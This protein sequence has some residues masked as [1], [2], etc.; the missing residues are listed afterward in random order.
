MDAGFDFRRGEMR[1][2]APKD[3]SR[4]SEIIDVLETHPGVREA[5][6]IRDCA[7]GYR[8]FVVPND[9]YMDNVLGRELAGATV[10]D[11]WRKACELS[12]LTKEVASVPVGFNTI[13]WNSTYTRQ[14]I[15]AD[16][17]REWVDATVA[18]ILKLEPRVVYE[19]GCGTG[20]PLLRI[21]P[22]CE[23][24]V[25]VD[26]S[27]VVL[28]RLREQL[29]TIPAARDRVELQERRADDFD[30]LEE[31]S[32]DTV[33]LNSIVQYFP[34]ATYLTSVLEKA[35]HVVKPGGHVFV[36]D[37]RNLNLLQVFAS[38][39]ETF[40]AADE[41]SAE[42]LR[43]RILRRMEREQE[44]VVSP[45]Y[46]LNLK[47]RFPKL[48]RVEIQPRCGRADNE[49]TH[50]RYDAILHVDGE[51]EASSG[52][53]FHDWKENTWTLDEIRSML[54]LHPNERQ[55][56][57][58]IRNARNE[59]DLAALAALKGADAAQ[60]AGK[61][62]R[63]S[64]Q[65]VTKGIHPQDCVDL[66]A[67]ELEFAVYLSWAACRPDGS[68]DVFFVPTAS[69]HGMNMP[70][71]DWPKLEASAL[72]RLTNAPGSGKLRNELV[73]QLLAHCKHNL[74]EDTVAIE[75]VLVD[76]MP[77]LAGGSVD[78]LALLASI[79]HAAF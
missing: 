8:A 70:A 76:A 35:I 20:M 45:A 44:L 49:M 10:V 37:T 16:E 4:E 28:A 56:I 41:T 63:E 74:A 19:I 68:F 64:N 17:M 47:S 59:R 13:G 48:S 14:P 69:L 72:V 39:V 29:Q 65:Y 1:R 53:E 38:S 36:G 42:D 66:M 67:E 3:N 50:Y 9:S 23:R 22:H 40:Q 54:S 52:D 24:Y 30:G 7:D 57:K 58:R 5:A 71:I 27:P 6:V 2:E 12:Q 25:A 51:T 60:T 33:V 26:F 77:R 75:I 31:N 46:F 79:E 21:A 11:R 34:N 55:G 43:H 73:N 62:R 32:F 15:P 78:S 18:E 61:L